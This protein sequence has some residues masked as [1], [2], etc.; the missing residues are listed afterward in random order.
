[1]IKTYDQDPS[2]RLARDINADI[3]ETYSLPSSRKPGNR[4]DLSCLLK[5]RSVVKSNFAAFNIHYCSVSSSLRT[6]MDHLPVAT[7]DLRNLQNFN[8]AGNQHNH[9]YATPAAETQIEGE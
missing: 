4:F 9:Y 8:I 6:I 7:A 1:M 2:E 5:V 3:S